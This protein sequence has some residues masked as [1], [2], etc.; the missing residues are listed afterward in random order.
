[1]MTGDVWRVPG[2]KPVD[3]LVLLALVDYGTRAFPKQETLAAKCGLSRCAVCRSVAR[4]RELGLITTKGSGKALRYVVATPKPAA[5]P[6]TNC[7]PQLQQVCSTATAAVAKSYRDPNYPIQ[8]PH[9][10]E[11]APTGATG[12]GVSIETWERI[13]VRDPR[14]YFEGTRNVVQRVLREHKLSEA[15]AIGAWRLLLEAWARTGTNAYDILKQHLGQ[16]EGSRDVGRVVLHR[17][18]GV[19]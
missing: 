7:S 10:P 8:R 15:D 13:L 17:I 4:L 2:L 6:R 3:R 19:A 5:Q 1:M 9:L 12:W 14:A 16:L 11:A 18:R